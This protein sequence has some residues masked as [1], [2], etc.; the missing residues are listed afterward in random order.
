[1]FAYSPNVTSE[2]GEPLLVLE[3]AWF[4]AI[5]P[6]FLSHDSRLTAKIR[7]SIVSSA[8]HYIMA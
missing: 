5:L 8:L 4:A 7:G 3:H 2:I 1:M 6:V